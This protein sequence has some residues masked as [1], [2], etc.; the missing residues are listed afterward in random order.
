MTRIL[1]LALILTAC[2]A[3]V[4]YQDPPDPCEVDAGRDEESCLPL[5]KRKEPSE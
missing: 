5:G 4:D 2:A 3:E 1:A